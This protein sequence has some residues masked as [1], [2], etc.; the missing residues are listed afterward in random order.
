MTAVRKGEKG[1]DMQGSFKMSVD[2]KFYHHG[3]YAFV[4][5]LDISFIVSLNTQKQQRRNVQVNE[6]RAVSEISCPG[7]LPIQMILAKSSTIFNMSP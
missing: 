2:V 4:S 1:G 6:I 5:N 7:G 3:Y